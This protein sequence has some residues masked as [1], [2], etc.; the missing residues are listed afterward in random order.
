MLD[1]R[2]LGAL[3]VSELGL[4]CMGMS[5]AYGPGDDVVPIP[6]TKRVKY[7]EENTASAD[8]DVPAGVLRELDTLGE[9]AGDRYQGTMMQAV[10]R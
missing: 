4:G 5:F 1:Q 8:V 10:E 6:G 9:A 3:I 7:L 2:T